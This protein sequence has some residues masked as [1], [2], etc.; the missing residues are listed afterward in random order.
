MNNHASLN[1]MPLI[2]VLFF[3][4][5]SLLW[6]LYSDIVLN[7]MILDA[8]LR[9]R[10]DIYLGLS[11]VVVMSCILYYLLLHYVATIRHYEQNFQTLADSG[12]AL[13]WL[14][15][16][17][18]LCTYFNKTWLEFT[19]RT[20]EQ[21]MGNGWAEGVHPDDLQCCL[22]IYIKSFDRRE[23]FSMGDNPY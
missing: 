12:Q 21:E 19:G 20:L 18:K 6:I 23:K 15:G 11:Y 8:S 22:D 4:V 17:D 13:V 9:F 1:R 10:T 7:Y 2:I 16:T 5:I 3:A 14:S